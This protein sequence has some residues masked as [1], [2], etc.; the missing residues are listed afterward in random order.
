MKR[1]SQKLKRAAA[2]V[3][4][5]AALTGGSLAGEASAF[6]FNPGDLVLAMYG[7]TNEFYQVLGDIN[8]L[9]ASSNNQ[10]DVTPGFTAASG[11]N[12]VKYA[13]VGFQSDFVTT[14][15]G[16]QQGAGPTTA[17]ASLAGYDS[18]ITTWQP[19]ISAANP[20]MPIAASNPLSFT[21]AFQPSPERLGGNFGVDQ[22]GTSGGG[23]LH[24]LSGDGVFG[25][26][27]LTEIATAMLELNPGNGQQILT[28]NP[29]PVPLPAAVWLF[30]TGLTGL[31]AIA[32][33]KKNVTNN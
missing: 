22:F 6:L 3:F 29:S 28:I 12:Q 11:A 4:T 1:F 18:T 25:D 33:R 19:N 2:A 32:R 13:L 17:S 16:S 26:G 15:S 7:N 9:A 21:N 14:V 24:L 10:F 30:G 5:A 31:V 27:T 8:T 23:L 20:S